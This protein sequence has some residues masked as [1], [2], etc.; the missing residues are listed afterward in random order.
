MLCFFLLFSFFSKISLAATAQGADIITGKSWKDF[1]G[2]TIDML[3]SYI[4]L[5]SN[6]LGDSTQFILFYDV[7]DWEIQACAYGV[8]SSTSPVGGTDVGMSLDSTNSVNVYD[9]TAAIN[10]RKASYA[11]GTALYTV[12]WYVQPKDTTI[13]YSVYLT[14]G[15]TKMYLSKYTNISA[16]PAQG[17]AG[18]DPEY[19]NQTFT[20]AVIEYSNGVKITSTQVADTTG[21]YE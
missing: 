17:S 4:G 13:I 8:S 19:F 10:A 15:R 5:N 1:G 11:D 3:G 9:F 6:R 20:Q 16:D 21:V 2:S 18:F 7:Y 12:S 14:D